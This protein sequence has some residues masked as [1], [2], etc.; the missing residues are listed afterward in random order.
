VT[1]QKNGKAIIERELMD[2]QHIIDV[3]EANWDDNKSDCNHFVKA[4]A[5]AL[6]V[7]LFSD[8]ENADAILK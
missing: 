3:C 8:G 6:G 2:P 5:N 7:T 1:R 4:V